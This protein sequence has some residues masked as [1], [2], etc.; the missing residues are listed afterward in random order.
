MTLIEITPQS[1]DVLISLTYATARNFTGVPVMCRMR[2]VICIP[3][4][5]KSWRKR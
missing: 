2:A 5:Q 4:Q 1:H 3:K